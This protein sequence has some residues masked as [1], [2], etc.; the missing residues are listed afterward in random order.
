[1]ASD[2]SVHVSADSIALDPLWALLPEPIW[3][4][5]CLFARVMHVLST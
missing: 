5:V 1:M 2:D 3:M 4:Q